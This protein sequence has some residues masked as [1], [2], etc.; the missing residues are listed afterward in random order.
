MYGTQVSFGA[1]GVHRF[2]HARL[3]LDYQGI[4]RHYTDNSFYDGTDHTLALGYTYQKSR[5]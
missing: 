4:Y 5:R 2:Q 1:Y 3:G